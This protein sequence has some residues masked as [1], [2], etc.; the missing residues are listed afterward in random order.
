[1]LSRTRN[2]DFRSPASLPIAVDL[3][4][5]IQLPCCYLTIK[6]WGDAILSLALL[7]FAVPVI[8]ICALLIKSTSRGSI[9]YTQ[10]RVGRFGR[11]FR[12]W[13]LRTMTHNCELTSGARWAMRKDPRTTRVGRVLRLTHLDELPQLWNVLK[14][15]MS[16]VGP[17]PERPEFIPVL[18]QA[19]PN[20]RERLLVRPGVT[21]AAQLNLPPDTG[22]DSVRNKLN[23]DLF[24]IRNMGF[25]LDLRMIIATPLQ[26]IGVPCRL[27]ALLLLL[28]RPE[29]I[30]PRKPSDTL[31][32]S[33]KPL[34]AEPLP[35]LSF[36]TRS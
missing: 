5:P 30:E 17:R 11:P 9:F 12:I 14:G 29:E 22:I 36:Q 10:T 32:L 8:A 13:K 27:V 7:A 18:E 1:M 24:Y 26:A 3:V 23:Y 25:W 33:S 6:R 21:G 20:Y 19:I 34:V 16:L 15:D 28:P 35:D 31:P 2:P 4:A